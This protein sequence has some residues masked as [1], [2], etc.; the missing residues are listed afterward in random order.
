MY[1]QRAVNTAYCTTLSL[2]ASY[3]HL[4]PGTVSY[5]LTL[6]LANIPLTVWA[7]S[8]IYCLAL[9]LADS[10]LLPDTVIS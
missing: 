5:C 3:H 10:T 1:I 7:D 8:A 2:A 9:S 6:P 4:L